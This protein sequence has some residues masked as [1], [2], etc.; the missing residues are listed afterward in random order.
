MGTDNVFYKG[1]QK[2]QKRKEEI[3]EQR[4]TT[5]LIVCEGAVT[6]KEYFEKLAQYINENGE[7]PI[8]VNVIGTG[9]NTI[10][11][12]RN[13]EDF[14]AEVDKAVG[15]VYIPYEKV[16]VVFD[17]DSFEKQQ[18]NTAIYMGEAKGYI[19]AW[20]NECFELWYLLHFHYFCTDLTRDEYFDKLGE[21]ISAQSGKKQKY[22]KGDA[23]NFDTM[24]QYG[25]LE[26]AIK[27]AERLLRESSFE[28]SYS[29]RKPAT[30]VVEIVKMLLEEGK[31]ILD[32][33][34][35]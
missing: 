32:E 25:S 30:N 15:K 13:V 9:K 2:R 6:E 1:T 11:L 23:N 26:N 22:I 29:N 12:V 16:C 8:E 21:F 5:W 19:V 28:T 27:N 31:C 33:K 24:M 17:K 10:S 34:N 20:S 18:F 35:K 3:M 4:A 7:H 14:F